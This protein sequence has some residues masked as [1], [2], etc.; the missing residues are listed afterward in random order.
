[1][2]VIVFLLIGFYFGLNQISIAQQN[3]FW[4][5]SENPQLFL[6]D[7]WKEISL[8]YNLSQPVQALPA[9]RNESLRKVYEIKANSE[10]NELSTVFKVFGNQIQSLVRGP[11][12]T[13]LF[14]PSDMNFQQGISDYALSLINAPQAWDL[15]Q[16]DDSVIIAISDQ[17]YD[18]SH[19]DLEGKYIYYDATNN[20]STTHGTAVAITAAGKTNNNY[21]L[22]S[23]GFNTGLAFYRMSFNEVLAASYAGADVINISWSSGCFYSQIEQDVMTEVAQNGSF[24]VAAA[25]NGNTCGLPDAHVYPASYELVF[26]VT[27]LGPSDNHE[28]WIGDP[29]STH[30]HNDSVDLAAPGYDV[31]V[32]PALNW[33]LNTSGTSFAAAYVSGTVGLMLAANKC[34]SN[35]DIENALKGSAVPINALNPSYTGKLGAGRLDAHQAVLAAMNV[36]NPLVPSFVLTDGCSA[37]DA[38]ATLLVQGGQFP[39][40][41]TWS[42]NY[43][44]FHDTALNTN[45][46]Q[47]QII[48]MHGC[49]LDTVVHVTDVVPPIY[50]WSTVNPTCSYSQ[51]GSIEILFSNNTPVSLSWSSGGNA[52]QILNLSG[53]TYTANLYYGSNCTIAETMVLTAPSPIQILGNISHEIT[54]GSGAVDLSVSGGTAPYSV[55]WSNNAQSEDLNALTAGYYDVTIVDAN[56]CQASSQFEIE[57]QTSNAGVGQEGILEPTL[58]PNP[59]QG[60]FTIQIP[61]NKS[62][63][64]TIYDVSGREIYQNNLSHTEYIQLPLS[65]GKYLVKSVELNTMN[66][67]LNTLLVY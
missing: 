45:T 32:S 62:Y 39:Y 8:Q 26:S 60:S 56:G 54:T 19:P 57:D 34:L 17:N 3:T 13:P 40:T 10:L 11:E 36:S 33:Y 20:T 63:L 6:S 2:K 23:I 41:A 48:D 24:V 12:Y 55:S 4:F 51:D 47:V 16:G 29:S 5:K 37:S 28:Q 42:N 27:S 21:G 65:K 18:V 50:Q 31:A 61:V 7:Q 67:Y 53:G 38:S 22:A 59:N 43:V 58:Y 49:T 64:I 1:M 14:V 15:S 30:N 35:V 9:S 52:P 25:G 66:F 44:G 46:Y